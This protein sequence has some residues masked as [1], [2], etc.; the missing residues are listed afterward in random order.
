LTTPE[1]DLDGFRRHTIELLHRW[2][3]AAQDPSASVRQRHMGTFMTESL[4]A[5][6]RL[7]IRMDT[8][9]LLFW[10]ALFM[11]DST[12][13]RAGQHY[14]LVAITRSFF[15]RIRPGIGARV[16]RVLIDANRRKP[17]VRLTRD[18][19]RLVDAIVRRL[20]GGSG[21][22]ARLAQPS[23]DDRV[24]S[25]RQLGALLLALAAAAAAAA[26]T[27]AWT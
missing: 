24:A 17:A 6:R 27:V 8:D 9:L 14:D 4:S 22:D 18:A 11:L 19:P 2:H 26:A 21:L 12:G 16:A 7:K 1:S 5:Y 23:I 10:R 15:E 3:R 20:R 25:R 13:L